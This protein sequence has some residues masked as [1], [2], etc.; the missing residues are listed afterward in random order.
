[1][2]L[3]IRKYEVDK[4]LGT[5]GQYSSK[6]KLKAVAF[7]LETGS[8]YKVHQLTG[9]PYQTVRQWHTEEW[10][11]D[12]EYDIKKQ[13]YAKLSKNTRNLVNMSD[14]VLKTRLEV[15]DPIYDQRLG[16][17]RYVPVKAAVVSKILDDAVKRTI[18]LDERDEKAKSG[19]TE[20]T[21]VDRLKAIQAMIRGKQ[22]PEL[23]VID[24]EVIN[25]TETNENLL[26]VQDQQ[27]PN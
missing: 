17:I 6:Q 27:T 7:Y 15:G 4:K 25:P 8:L 21:I 16:D 12:A 1:M 9:F 5:T 10:W 3:K 14:E 18:S 26:E 13:R 24:I 19:Q 22:K 11:K 23:P 2:V 20:E